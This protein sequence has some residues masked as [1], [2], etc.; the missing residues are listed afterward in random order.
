M[1]DCTAIEESELDID[2]STGPVPETVPKTRLKNLIPLL[3]LYQ[4]KKKKNVISQ[5]ILSQVIS[6]QSF[7]DPSRNTTYH[8]VV[9]ERSANNGAGCYSHSIAYCTRPEDRHI[10]SNPALSI[11]R[12]KPESR[13]WA[14]RI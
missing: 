8:T 7:Q 2:R 12:R 6:V 13:Q 5:H 14:A 9:W 10:T 11:E 1:E 3:L 4:L